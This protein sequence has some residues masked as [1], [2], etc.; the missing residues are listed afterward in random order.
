MIIC[1]PSRSRPQRLRLL[2]EN[3][4]ATG[5]TSKV[6]I[7]LD[8]DDPRLQE[9]GEIPHRFIVGPRV[10]PAQCLR[11]CFDFFPHE[12]C[13][14]MMGDDMAIHTNEWD[15]KL[16]TAA[17]RWNVAYPDDGLKGETLAT[18][19]FIGGEFVR[20]M[21]FLALP[22]LYMLFADTVWD[23]LGRQYG[24][25]IYC[26]EIYLEHLH[27]SAGKAVRDETYTKFHAGEDQA[28]FLNWRGEFKI[29]P[30]ILDA[31]KTDRFV[32]A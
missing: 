14:G 31:I 4:K 21:G 20:A 26:P 8:D 7:R 32:A 12:D 16:Q 2:L 9:Y 23:F 11:E 1:L 28:R 30:V 24:N 6:Y 5:T 3:M 29:D 18:H 27:W 25:L 19:P 17:G 10:G 13:Y 22:G 15:R